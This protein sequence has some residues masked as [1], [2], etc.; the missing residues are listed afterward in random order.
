M[1]Y[2]E[3]HYFD[4]LSP[5][6]KNGYNVSKIA[7][8]NIGKKHP[9]KTKKKIG[10]IQRGVKR[11]PRSPEIIAKIT[12]ANTGKKH[13]EETKALM[14]AQRKERKTSES[15]KEKLRT[16]FTGRKVSEDV[17]QQISRSLMGHKV[18]DE[19]R[20]KIRIAASNPSNETRAKQRASHIRNSHTQESKNKI[21]SSLKGIPKYQFTLQR[22]QNFLALSQNILQRNYRWACHLR[23]SLVHQIIF[24]LS[25]LLYQASKRACFV[26]FSRKRHTI[27]KGGMLENT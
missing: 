19:A 27:N 22:A 20:D 15:T 17:E 6:G 23:N 1:L 25:E 11:G 13:S 21:S 14:S 16:I 9:E 26:I 24:L 18:S 8:S 12:A 5:F 3:Q 4:T 2:R 7:G 10:D